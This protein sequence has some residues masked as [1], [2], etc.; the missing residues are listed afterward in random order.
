MVIKSIVSVIT[1]QVMLSIICRH[2]I[3]NWK[4]MVTMFARRLTG[5]PTLT[6]A[7]GKVANLIL[8]YRRD[9]SETRLERSWAATGKYS[10]GLRAIE[11]LMGRKPITVTTS[12][13]RTPIRLIRKA[14]IEQTPV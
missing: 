13:D 8:P 11:I 7:A 3:V 1:A 6:M 5:H 2:D 14:F 12:M 10:P 9:A 4:H